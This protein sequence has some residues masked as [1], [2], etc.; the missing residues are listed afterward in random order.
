MQ[1][2]TS[3][4]YQ[5]V[6]NL[7]Q[8]PAD[9]PFC[10]AVLADIHPGRIFVDDVTQPQTALV[11]RDDAWCFL[12]GDPGNHAFNRALNQAL[13]NREVVTTNASML[14]F[15][16][17]PQNW[18]GNLRA[19]FAP[20]EPIP[21]RRRR[22]VGHR[23]TYDWQSKLPEGV[24]VQPMDESLLRH[25]DLRVPD[26]V[27]QTIRKWRSLTSSGG[28]DFGFVAIHEGAIQKRSE[29]ASWATV[30]A[31]AESVGD[32]GIFTVA[33]YRGRGLATLT[34]AATI[35]HALARGLSA[36]NWTCAESNTGSIR[37]AEK[38]G[39]ERHSDY[40]LYYLVFDEAQH[41]THLAYHLL[42]G[43]CYREAVGLLEPVLTLA[44]DQ[45][46]WL[47][48]DAARAW[49][50]LAEPDRALDAL[51]QAVDRGWRD[52]DGT[53]ACKEFEPLHRMPEWDTVL[54]RMS[55]AG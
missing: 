30:D 44:D 16:C 1:K 33:R 38:L 41:V 37:I 17:H 49:A 12:G 46:F 55:Q 20:R 15:T 10:T 27:A 6:R 26:E 13:W 4:Q 28:Q 32:A 9:Q 36:V 35:E 2:L 48:H 22:Y 19:V 8:P 29:I 25:P 14:L 21:A 34:T 24:R 42:E 53:R 52:R 31:V 47:Y 7:F 40:L 50:A 54:E 39:F 3:D 51:N 45:P 5:K 43:Q 18:L 11:A 23:I